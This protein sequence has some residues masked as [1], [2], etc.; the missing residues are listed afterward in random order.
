MANKFYEIGKA[1]GEKV[2]DYSK[3]IAPSIK[4]MYEQM[5]ASKEKLDAFMIKTPQGIAMDKVPEQARAYVTK[6]LAEGKQ[7]YAQ[8]ASVLSSGINP[9]SQRYMDAVETMNKVQNSFENLNNQLT[10]YNSNVETQVARVDNIAEGTNAWK[11]TD[12]NNYVTGD[13]FNGGSIDEDGNISYVSADTKSK[14]ISKWLAPGQRGT[15][16]S[17][18]FRAINGE[19]MQHK[20]NGDSWELISTKYEDDYDTI[21][22]NLGEEGTKDMV[23][24]DDKYMQTLIT[25]NKEQDPDGYL[26]EYNALVENSNEAIKGYKQYNMNGWKAIYDLSTGPKAEIIESKFFDGFVYSADDIGGYSAEMKS[27]DRKKIDARKTYGDHYGRRGTYIYDSKTDT[28]SVTIP[29]V[30][31]KDGS[32]VLIPEST[33]TY[34]PWQVLKEE[35]LLRDGET[36]P[37]KYK[38]ASQD[39]NNTAPVAP[40]TLFDVESIV[41]NI[42]QDIFMQKA[43]D[44][45]NRLEAIFVNIPGFKVRSTERGGVIVIYNNKRVEIPAGII[46]KNTDEKDK[47]A[48]AKSKDTLIKWLQTVAIKPTI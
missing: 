32:K 5:I 26:E 16:G 8:A 6:F 40:E 47:Q 25:A 12:F 39:N 36:D 41:S 11:L 43:Q 42:N 1:S 2:A 13:I 31:S 24:S 19:I 21:V 18:T 30:M 46:G 45:A 7:K 4:S 10:N 17:E 3:S 22:N 35:N 14:Q 44:A 9:S 20:R 48:I 23:F 37:S 33:K 29:A 38:A 28:Y 27:S 34:T 15:R